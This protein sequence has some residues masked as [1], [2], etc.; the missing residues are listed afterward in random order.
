VLSAFQDWFSVR[1]WDRARDGGKRAR[2]MLISMILRLDAEVVAY[3]LAAQPAGS[4][5]NRDVRRSRVTRS[6]I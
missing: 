5:E 1:E 3:Y 2:D 6:S 4:P